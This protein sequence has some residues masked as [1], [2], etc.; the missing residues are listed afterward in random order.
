VDSA[1]KKL[2]DEIGKIEKTDSSEIFKELAWREERRG[3]GS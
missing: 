2:G 1:V 3:V